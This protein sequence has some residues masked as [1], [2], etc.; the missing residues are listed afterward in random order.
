MQIF[1][2]RS[3]F[4][5]SSWA[6]S[7][8]YVRLPVRTET[9]RCAMCDG[10]AKIDRL[11]VNA[12]PTM[13]RCS[14]LALCFQQLTDV[15]SLSVV[16][17]LGRQRPAWALQSSLDDEG[18]GSPPDDGLILSDIDVQMAKLRSMY[19]TSEADY[20]AM[21]RARNAAKAASV[22]EGASDTDWHQVAAEARERVG[23]VDDWEIAANE[24]GNV[25]SQ[26]LIPIELME[27]ENSADGGE[28]D[29][30]KL[31]LF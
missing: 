27:G 14:L 20:L 1:L 13:K 18:G 5:G 7:S 17:P 30:P 16:R 23:G 28:A 12:L 9:V 3:A 8:V 22:N 2:C 6:R 25:D 11:T 26:I 10:S 29:E 21:A 15:S 31:M 24:A 19:P 4:A